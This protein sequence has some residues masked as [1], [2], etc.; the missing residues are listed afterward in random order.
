MSLPEQ[1]IWLINATCYES[2]KNWRFERDRMGIMFWLY[3]TPIY[4]SAMHYQYQQ[5]FFNRCDNNRY[6]DQVWYKYSTEVSESNVQMDTEAARR[7]RKIS[8]PPLFAKAHLWDGGVYDNHGL[9]GLHSFR[10]GWRKGIDFLIVSDAAGRSK[11]ESYHAGSRAFKR[12]ITGIMM[13]QIRSLRS[14][15]VLERMINHKDE[16]RGCFIQVGNTL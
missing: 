6:E 9:E 14:R 4:R 3:S 11:P 16:D 2:G 1:P 13:D 10:S 12:I 7:V 5:D 15:A 8:T